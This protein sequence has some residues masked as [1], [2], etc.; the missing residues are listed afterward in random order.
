[1][2]THHLDF[3]TA[4]AAEHPAAVP[5]LPSP[6]F[7]G[8]T[9]MLASNSP[10][11]R[12]LLGLILPAFSIAPRRDIDEAYPAD[13]APADVPA[14]LSR[15]KA[16][17][18]AD[19]L[20]SDM[21]LITADTVVISERAESSEH[22]EFSEHSECS[23]ILGKPRSEAEACEMLRS[24][25]GRTHTVVTGVT[26]RSGSGRRDETFSESTRVTFGPLT[27]S[28][29]AQYVLRYRPLDKAGAYGI[30]E[31]LGAAAIARI[32]GCFYNVMGLPLH[33]LYRHLKAYF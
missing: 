13:L 10:R 23:K 27:D 11:R 2:N 14:Y 7:A 22:S 16:D 8:K 24:L 26:L 32:D 12:E 25:A 19:L 21:L 5:P 1:M 20:T 30:Q 15:L 31:W 28:E 6:A 33:A 3:N 18:Y 9:V 29:I 17:A 4:C